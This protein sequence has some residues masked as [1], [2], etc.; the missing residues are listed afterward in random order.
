MKKKETALLKYYP[1]G[2]DSFFVAR[3]FRVGR[4]Q[5]LA[6]THIRTQKKIRK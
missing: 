1:I 5:F 3:F 6:I 4:N 2:S